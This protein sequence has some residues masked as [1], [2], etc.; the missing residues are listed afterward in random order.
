MDDGRIWMGTVVLNWIV[1][2]GSLSWLTGPIFDKEL[3]VS[4]RRRRNYV[5]RFAYIALF[6]FVLSLIWL[7]VVS[8]DSSSAYQSSRMAA[9]GKIIMSVVL[10]FEFIAV[11]LIAIVM[12][13]TSISD[14]IYGRTLGV[15]M[16]TPI[17]SVQIVV[18]KLLSKLLQLVLLLAITLPL[19]AI[20]RVFGGVPWDYL[21]CSLC[22]I[23]TTGLLVGSLSLLFSIFTRRAYVV[24]L[25]VILVLVTVFLFIPMITMF[26]VHRVVSERAF[27]NVLLYV[28][29]Y[30]V[31]AMAIDA[32]ESAKPMSTV[33]WQAHC[34][35]SLGVS[36]L[37]LF[38]STVLVRKAALR[39]ATGQPGLWSGGRKLGDEAARF[40]QTRRVMGAPVLWKERRMPLLGRRK[41]WMIAA[42]C[43]A[44]ALL[45]LTYYGCYRE[46]MLDEEEAQTTYIVIF[47]GLGMLF[48]VVLPATCI[49]SEKESRTWPLLLTTTTGDGDIITGK[50]VG[51]LRRC[52]PAWLF[53]VGHVLLFTLMGFIHPFGVVQLAILVVWVMFFL[54]STGVYF[55]VRFKHTTTAVIANMGLAAGLW[56]IF[57]LLLGLLLM[58]TH[59]DTDVLEVYLDTNPVVHAIVI[60]LASSGRGGIDD[61]EW[62]NGNSSSVFRATAWMLLCFTLYVGVAVMFTKRAIKRL[63]LNSF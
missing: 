2:I 8:Y 32:L 36:A 3:R 37:L 62:V 24:I 1:R 60:A 59:A 58:G 18:G 29:P 14:E 9:A 19:M 33:H 40:G 63:R 11:Q 13:S 61:Y 12:L 41:G 35:L 4:S 38:V 10:W 42:I 43:L 23:L 27:V 54:S 5:L 22:A 50:L 55:S 51:A 49:T 48:S 20:V 30:V 52:L 6:A 47:L 44:L 34:G 56:A 57:P 31:M 28:N 17:G 16:T 46:E 26:L 7:D 53:L 15:L 39:Q 45:A 21:L 25:V